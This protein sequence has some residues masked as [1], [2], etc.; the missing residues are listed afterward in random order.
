M[1][2]EGQQQKDT[3]AVDIHGVKVELSKA[4]ADKLIAGRDADKL[5]A[6][7]YQEKLGKLE[8]DTQAAMAKAAKSEEDRL[9]LEA[10]KKG[11]MD[12]VRALMT[13]EH[14][15]REAKLSAKARDK[16][17][18]AL[19]AGN[20]NI[21]KTAVADIVDQ[22]RTR[23]QYN[24]DTESVTVIDEAGQPLKSQDG[25]PVEVDAFL[26]T[27]LE[28]RP[29]YLLDKTPKGSGG[30]GAKGSQGSKTVSAAAL[31]AMAPLE[32]AK[33]LAANVGVKVQ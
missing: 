30:E 7:E 28:N 9:A 17:L 22:L 8:A 25:K 14:R 21:A 29:H 15:E 16:H 1:T 6:R 11:E 27:W 5:R 13:K 12:Q 24:F 10:A 32:R 33:F 3:V 23:T 19:V 31:E 18:A 20:A 4:D 26:G 2:T